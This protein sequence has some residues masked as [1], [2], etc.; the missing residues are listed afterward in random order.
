M[1]SIAYH[2]IAQHSNRKD[3]SGVHSSSP[4]LAPLF[5]MLV[6]LGGHVSCK[7]LQRDATFLTCSVTLCYLCGEKNAMQKRQNYVGA[8]LK[9]LPGNLSIATHAVIELLGNLLRR[10]YFERGGHGRINGSREIER[11]NE[12]A[13]IIKPLDSNN[14]SPPCCRPQRHKSIHVIHCASKLVPTAVPSDI[15]PFVVLA[16]TLSSTPITPTPHDCTISNVEIHQHSLSPCER[17]CG[18]TPSP[19]VLSRRHR[20]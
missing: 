2:S 9:F 7:V 20:G 13:L 16:G 5:C 17:V 10:R 15:S 6:H 1:R 19:T 4:L 18:A 11:I 8:L 14:D 12:P 3:N